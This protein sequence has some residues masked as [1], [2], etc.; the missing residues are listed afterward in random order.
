LIKTYTNEG[1]I[2]LDNA[3]GSGTTAIACMNL[4]RNYIL[5]EKEQKYYDIS[6][7]RIDEHDNS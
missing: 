6:K 3:S 2:I 4:K 5:I 7:K 1:D